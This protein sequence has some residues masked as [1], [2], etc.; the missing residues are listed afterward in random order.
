VR[1]VIADDNLLIRKG[2]AA[3]PAEAGVLSQHV[4]YGVATRVLAEQ[5]A[6]LGYL[7]KERVT[8]VDDFVG[9]LRRVLVGGTALDLQ[10][11][12]ALLEAEPDGG[13]LDTLT[14]RER[15]VMQ[16]IAEGFSNPA[17]SERLGIAPEHRDVRLGDLREARPARHGHRAP[18]RP[19]RAAVP[20]GL[21]AGAGPHR[22]PPEHRP[23]G[24]QQPRWRRN[25][26]NGT[27]ACINPFPEESPM[28]SID[29]RYE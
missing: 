11:V 21:T 12:S 17:I 6:R 23:S 24:H 20:R 5:P 14:P 7:L 29:P 18:A 13:P 9:A 16:L 25:P 3:L 22:R 1:V 19:R 15:E 27:L 4:E 2:I 28:K 10:V 26:A 8:D